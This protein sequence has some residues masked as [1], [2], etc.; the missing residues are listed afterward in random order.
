MPER[1]V[2]YLLVGG[3]LASAN[4]A[5]WL[6]EAGADGSILLV[7]REPDPPYNRPPLTKGYLRGSESREDALFRPREWWREQ[8]VELLTRTSVMRL[9]PGERVARL[10]TGD[11]V[12]FGKALLATGANVRRLRV[13]GCE[14]DGIHYVRAFGNA[15]AIREEAEQAER[16]VMIGGSY[17]GTEAAAS[18]TALGR[19]CAIVMMEEVTLER[20]CGREVGAYFQRV[21]EEHGVEI[22]G[23]EEVE[24]FEGS[25]GR[26]RRVVLK[27]GKELEADMVVVGVGVTPDVTLARQAGLEIGASGGVRCDS[28]LETSAPGIFAAGDACEFESVVHG[29]R[30][31]LEHWDVAFTHGKAAALSMLG[32][33]GP[34]EEVPYFFSD[35][36]EWTGME[37]V[38][39]G[40]GDLVVRG[41]LDDGDFTAFY[42]ADGRVTAALT[43]GRSGDL[44]HAR[45]FIKERTPVE[46]AA[47]ADEDSDLADLQ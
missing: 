47:L 3:G 16:V 37:Y 40:S 25:D 21:L 17:I 8:E 33:G 34:Y 15:D 35:L 41:S 13:E 12:R 11:E 42:L 22:H 19:R 7:G 29:A 4:C 43:V 1:S 10:S 18:L 45:R 24:R 28:R 5:R 6:R 39:P 31:R 32:K 46:R 14:L 9:D 26:V 44:D 30:M 38:G 27:S 36:A 23:C 20:L 2:E